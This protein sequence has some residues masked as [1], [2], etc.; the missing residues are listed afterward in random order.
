[1]NFICLKLESKAK[2]TIGQSPVVSS[3]AEEE[4]DGDEEGEE[5][6]TRNWKE[7][8]ALNAEA[9]MKFQLKFLISQTEHV[10]FCIHPTVFIARA[11]W[12]VSV[13]CA[14]CCV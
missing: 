12:I 4:E 3:K 9:I 2:V 7:F 14:V 5:T 11:N 8:F 6:A 1:M 10:H 13:C